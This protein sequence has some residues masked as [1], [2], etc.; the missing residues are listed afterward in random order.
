MMTGTGVPMPIFTLLTV[1]VRE[2]YTSEGREFMHRREDRG[3]LSWLLGILHRW[4]LSCVCLLSSGSQGRRYGAV[5]EPVI[6]VPT[7]MA[8]GT[9]QFPMS[10]RLSPATN[11]QIG[12]R[13]LTVEI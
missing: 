8:V 6:G 12:N 2:V 9:I 4:V 11:N 10:Q 7:P 13:Y 1:F 5:K 3:F